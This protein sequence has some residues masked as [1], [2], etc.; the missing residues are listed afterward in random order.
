MVLHATYRTVDCGS[1]LSNQLMAGVI[2]AIELI[3]GKLSP[4]VR[5]I[6]WDVFY[7]PN[8]CK[9][10]YFFSTI[11]NARIRVQFEDVSKDEKISGCGKKQEG[12]YKIVTVITHFSKASLTDPVSSSLWH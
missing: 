11:T 6:M 8:S 4:R 7:V 2:V 3:L 10:L 1:S 5:T 12:L 9:H